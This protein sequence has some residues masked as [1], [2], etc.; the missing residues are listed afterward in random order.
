GT[1][2]GAPAVNEAN[3]G[4]GEIALAGASAAGAGG[5][6]VIA[7]VTFNV[8]SGTGS[9]PLNIGLD[10]LTAAGTFADL[11]GNAAPVSG[12]FC[13]NSGPWGDVVRDGVL[14]ANDA[15]AVLTASV[16]LPIAPYDLTNADVDADGKDNAR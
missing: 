11:L 6:V 13:A 5:A 10:E 4:I 3:S 16:G 7:Q 1:Y 12:L 14:L 9:T 15:L 2:A 8:L